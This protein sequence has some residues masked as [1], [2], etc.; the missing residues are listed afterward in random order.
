MSIDRLMATTETQVLAA[1]EE[2]GYEGY[3]VG[4][5]VRDAVMDRGYHDIDITTNAMPEE[6]KAVFSD[7]RII[8][9]G[10]K[11]G[12]V[13]VM[14][15]GEPIEI[16]TYRSESEY[17]DH[18]HP[19][20]VEFVRNITEDLARR[21]FT[22][23][24]MAVSRTGEIVDPFGGMADI[25]EGIIRAVGNPTTRF[26]EDALRIMRA[27]RFAAQLGFK[28]ERETRIAMEE[29]AHLLKEISAERVY[30]EFKKLVVAPYAPQVIGRHVEVISAVIPHFK[31]MHGFDQRNHAHQYDVLNHCLH[32]LANIRTTPENEVYMKL[33]ALFHDIGK[34]DTFVMIDDE[35][36][37]CPG[38]PAKSAEYVEEIMQVL[39]ADAFTA[40][41]VRLI[42]E[43][44][45]LY[46]KPDRVLLKKWLHKFGPEVLYEILEIKR[47]DNLAVGCDVTQLIQMFDETKVLLD[48]ILENGD[49]YSYKQLAVTGTDI[50]DRGF[51][52]RKVGEILRDLLY[53]VIAEELPNDRD[54]L[55]QVV[56]DINE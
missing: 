15:D 43:Y 45:D 29:K 52:G 39:K 40:E 17:S 30:A 21:D 9:T 6:T 19:D 24:A 55:L 4:G 22:I 23:N 16:T 41:R 35:I 54:T 53:K 42:T 13:M 28:I 56:D 8:E 32:C 14:W 33:A 25:E 34:P 47:A 37:R 31:Q 26:E 5:C 1:L 3:F 51:K 44:H 10:I 7:K 27:V 12:T 36:G 38:H 11:H 2:A 20:K 48:D 49:C 50:I 46:F 18:R